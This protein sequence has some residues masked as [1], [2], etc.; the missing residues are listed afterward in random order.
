MIP[1]GQTGLEKDNKYS[2][3]HISSDSFFSKI[4]K[5]PS[6]VQKKN[7]ASYKRAGFF[8]EMKQKKI[9]MVHPKNWVVRLSDVHN[10]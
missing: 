8:I 2:C 7:D 6:V 4:L 3:V 5:K 1:W 9:K 10:L